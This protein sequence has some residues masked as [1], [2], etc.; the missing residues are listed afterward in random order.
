MTIYSLQFFLFFCLWPFLQAADDVI[1]WGTKHFLSVARPLSPSNHI[2]RR[3]R[4]L[5]RPYANSLISSTSIFCSILM[6]FTFYMRI[7]IYY[8]CYFETF[9]II[10]FLWRLLLFLLWTDKIS[11][12]CL[13]DRIVDLALPIRLKYFKRKKS[14][15]AKLS[16]SV[17]R[18]IHLINFLLLLRQHSNRLVNTCCLKTLKCTSIFVVQTN[19]QC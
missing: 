17:D 19:L 7:H 3:H 9:V 2:S 4:V 11:N 18:S 6:Y 14:E 15:C 1:A 8:V 16:L 5:Y 10:Q 12:T 13:N